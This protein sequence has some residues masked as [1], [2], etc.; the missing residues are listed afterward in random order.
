VVS[1][2]VFLSL[3]F[4]SRFFLACSQ[5]S[6]IGCLPYFHTSCGRSAN[7]GCRSETCC[8]R[9]AKNT[10]RKKS[11]KIRHWGTIV[12]LCQAISSQLRH[13]SAIG[14]KILLSSNISSTCPHDMANFS[15]LVA[16]IGSVV[17]GTPG[18]FNRFCI[19]A[20][21]LHGTPAVG[22]SQSLRR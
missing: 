21:L 12:Q 13:V 6:E 19:L 2:S 10:G 1:S 7:L 11:P 9:L 14:K 17:W 15:P 5:P 4:I 8:T 18:K 3:V 20:A 22:V 16:E